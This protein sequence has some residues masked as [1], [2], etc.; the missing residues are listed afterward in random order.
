MI[1]LTGL[2]VKPLRVVAAGQ[3][4]HNGGHQP[5]PSLARD[6]WLRKRAAGASVLARPRPVR[7]SLTNHRCI[8]ADEAAR[9]TYRPRS[10]FGHRKN[11]RTCEWF[12]RSLN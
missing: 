7:M 5:R 3:Q 11:T 2:R 1:A 9:L 6:A 12:C 10:K 8:V 4:S